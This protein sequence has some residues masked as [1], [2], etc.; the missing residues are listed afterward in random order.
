L[1]PIA[2]AHCSRQLFGSP[3]AAPQ[4][5]AHAAPIART[6]AKQPFAVALHPPVQG[7]IALG[8]ADDAAAG[9]HVVM[10]SVRVARQVARAA[11]QLVIHAARHWKSPNAQ[12]CRQ[13][14]SAVRA[15]IAHTPRAREQL[16]VHCWACAVA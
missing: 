1:A 8:A 9:G 10:Q 11:R 16:L 5:S 4:P 15:C 6:S 14:D 2:A 3:P 13:P 7:I 12:P